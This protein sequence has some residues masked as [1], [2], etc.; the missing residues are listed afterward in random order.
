MNI[1][2]RLEGVPEKVLDKMIKTGIASNKTEA[3][4]VTIMEYA[5][6]HFTSLEKLEEDKDHVKM[7]G[8]GWKK[9]L[10]DKKEDDTMK[11]AK[12]L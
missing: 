10:E 4:R 12:M 1:T 9:Y 8:S 11:K 2:L 5:E 3:I 7:Q 6:H